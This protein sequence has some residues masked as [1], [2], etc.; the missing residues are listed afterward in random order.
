MNHELTQL[1]GEPSTGLLRIRGFRDFRGFRG[2]CGFGADLHND[3]RVSRGFGADL[4]LGGNLINEMLNL[5]K[6]I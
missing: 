2:F 5:R 4:V 6:Y 3:F 1:Y